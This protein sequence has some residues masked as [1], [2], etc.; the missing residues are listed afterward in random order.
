MRTLTE[1][2]KSHES[3]SRPERFGRLLDR[4]GP[5]LE[6]FS[7][8]MG[9]FV[10]C[11]FCDFV[12]RD[13]FEAV[14]QAQERRLQQMHEQVQTLDRQV[15]TMAATAARGDTKSS[16]APARQRLDESQRRP[17][18]GWLETA[19]MLVVLA[20][21]AWLCWNRGRRGAIGDATRYCL[22][23]A[24]AKLAIVMSD[25]RRSIR[26]APHRTDIAKRRPRRRRH[27]RHRK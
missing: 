27:R 18:R 22:D 5:F 20:F 15:T 11:V 13:T 9:V 2:A 17:K 24:R 14:W 25:R 26:V 3:S 8:L 7:P 10:M 23:F 12:S 1:A 16:A 19:I 4:A 21:M 6:F